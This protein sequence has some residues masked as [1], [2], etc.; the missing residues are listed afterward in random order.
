[1]STGDAFRAAIAA[2]TELGELAK[3]YLDRGDLVPDD[4]TIGIVACQARRDRVRSVAR[5]ARSGRCSTASRGRSRRRKVWIGQLERRGESILAVVEI[6]VPREELIERLSGRRVCPICG[7]IYHVAFNPPKQLR[8]FAIADGTAL[9]PAADDT[10]D[11]IARR[12]DLYFDMTAPLLDY[13]RN[14]GLLRPSMGCNRSTTL[15]QD[16][17]DVVAS[18]RRRR[19]S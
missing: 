4:V 12:L 13:Y 19:L 1:M 11:A 15:Q 18:R 17:V 8:V 3:G 9:D 16:I 5:I 14:R 2:K 7:A 6:D 10:P